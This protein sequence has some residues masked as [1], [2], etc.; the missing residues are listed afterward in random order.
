[1]TKLLGSNVIK[2]LLLESNKPVL[3]LLSDNLIKLK[4][5]TSCNR[6]KEIY[7]QDTCKFIDLHEILSESLENSEYEFWVIN[8]KFN[9]VKQIAWSYIPMTV[10]KQ[11]KYYHNYSF[12][13]LCS[14]NEYIIQF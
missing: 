8:S 14:N 7:L 5:Y 6:E 9:L 11:I 12:M 13:Y 10:H 3:K 2:P 4:I 1:M